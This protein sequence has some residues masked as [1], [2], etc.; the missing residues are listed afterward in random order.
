MWLLLKNR[1]P[2]SLTFQMRAVLSWSPYGTAVPSSAFRQSQCNPRAV[3]SFA[4][5]AVPSSG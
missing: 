1:S 3:R 4:W 2:V 5:S